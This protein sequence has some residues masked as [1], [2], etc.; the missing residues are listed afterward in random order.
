[1]VNAFTSLQVLGTEQRASMPFVLKG[2]M[3]SSIVLCQGNTLDF[4]SN[5]Q[6]EEFTISFMVRGVEQTVHIVFVI[7]YVRVISGEAALF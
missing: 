1:M 6:N 7:S 4:C 5:C 3:S 2:L